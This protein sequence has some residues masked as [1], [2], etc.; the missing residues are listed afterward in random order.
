[1]EIAFVPIFSGDAKTHFKMHNN[2]A[3]SFIFM[4]SSLC[5][6]LNMLPGSYIF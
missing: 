5:H 2:Y 1:M 6:K 4:V 3:K